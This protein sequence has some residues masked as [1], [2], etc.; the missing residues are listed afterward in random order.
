[1]DIKPTIEVGVDQCCTDKTAHTVIIHD[2]SDRPG[3]MWKPAGQ[4]TVPTM[5]SL[6]GPLG[7]L[8]QKGN[9]RAVC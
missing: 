9:M 1:M 2:F 7:Q 3:G 4:S 8:P 5:K 6:M